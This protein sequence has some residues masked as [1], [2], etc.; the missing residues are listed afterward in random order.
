MSLLR[1]FIGSLDCLCPL[2][3]ARVITL[4]FWLVHWI[5]CVLCDWLEWLLWFWFYDTKLKTALSLNNQMINNVPILSVCIWCLQLLGSSFISWCSKGVV[6]SWRS[7]FSQDCTSGILL[8]PFNVGLLECVPLGWSRSG[9][10]IQDH[11][12]RDALKE[13]I[14]PLWSRI[15]FIV[16]FDVWWSEWSWIIDRDLDNPKETHPYWDFSRG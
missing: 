2:W 9:S 12:D 15:G 3:L 5:V 8:R 16:S 10:M 14:N 1:V 4:S 7:A 6:S 13:V 11:S